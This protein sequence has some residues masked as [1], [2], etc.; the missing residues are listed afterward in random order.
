MHASKIRCDEESYKIFGILKEVNTAKVRMYIRVKRSMTKAYHFDV[1]P[2]LQN[3]E[4]LRAPNTV[5]L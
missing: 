5:R 2:G 4:D 1:P 3:D